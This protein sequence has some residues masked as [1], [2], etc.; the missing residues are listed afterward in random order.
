MQTRT[1]GP[2][3]VSA[4]GLGCMSMSQTYNP[5]VS[6][7]D[8]ARL[9][10]A[11][12]DAGITH[13][14][15]AALY[16]FGH[17]ETLVGPVLKPHR[18]RI[19]LA[20][21]GGVGGVAGEDGL[22]RR[23]IDGRP[24]SL[25]RNIEDSLRRLGAEVIDLYYLHRWDRK[26]PVEESIGALGEAK[27]KGY[28]RAIGISEVSAETLRRAHREAP[29]AALQ[30]EY[31]LWTRNPEIAVLE[32]CRKLGVAFVAFSPV[33]RGFLSGALAE[34]PRFAEGDFRRTNPRFSGE[35]WAKN[36]ALLPEYRRIAADAG[37]TP[38]QFALAWL[39]A[40]GGDILPIPGT[41]SLAHL[42][43][44]VGAA[45][46]SLSPEL[47]GRADALINQTT[48]AGSRYTAQTQSEVDTE[49]F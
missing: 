11:A 40:K 1:L 32:E 38:A 9:I 48:V 15:T 37:C 29:I 46:V 18:G 24:A 35:N 20:S 3:T 41:Q 43:E 21:K 13:F 2:F 44:N 49:Q 47:I 16:G 45:A 19:T 17:N 7:E 8:G 27:R 4:I 39:M 34:E 36:R 23:V 33:A 30:T 6:A 42:A 25:M 5:P 28:I 31:S 26:V 22:V 14:D 12:L 10:H